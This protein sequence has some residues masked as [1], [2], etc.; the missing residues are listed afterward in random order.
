MGATGPIHGER[1]SKV[2]VPQASKTLHESYCNR[3]PWNPE[4]IARSGLIVG[5]FSMIDRV[6]PQNPLPWLWSIT[7]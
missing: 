5:R 7:L 4:V 2:A 6:T 3:V 1:L